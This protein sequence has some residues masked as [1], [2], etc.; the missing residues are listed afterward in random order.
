MTLPEDSPEANFIREQA[1][2]LARQVLAMF[3]KSKLDDARQEQLTPVEVAVALLEQL[4]EALCVDLVVRAEDEGNNEG[5]VAP[6][7]R[8]TDSSLNGN[9]VVA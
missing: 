5:E 9:P 2:R 4:R 8:L 7:S 3:G 1:A 6:P